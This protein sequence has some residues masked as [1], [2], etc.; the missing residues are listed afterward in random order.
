[1][2]KVLEITPESNPEI[3][4]ILQPPAVPPQKEKITAK[5]S[6]FPLEK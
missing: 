5:D 2:T 1:M 6:Q 3:W 4:A